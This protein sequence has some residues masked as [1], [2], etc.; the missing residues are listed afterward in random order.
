MTAPLARRS[1]TYLIIESWIIQTLRRWLQS[2]GFS[3]RDTGKGLL[4]KDGHE[5]QETISYR[6]KY[7]EE[8]QKL[9]KRSYVYS[10]LTEPQ[11]PVLPV[12]KQECVFVYHDECTF[13]SNDGQS[14]Y[15]AEVGE[16]HLKPKQQG[17]G[18]MVSGFLREKK[19]F[20]SA[21]VEEWEN[22]KIKQPHLCHHCHTP[23]H[24]ALATLSQFMAMYSLKIGKANATIHNPSGYWIADDVVGQTNAAVSIFEAS[25][26][27][28]QGVWI[29]DN[30]TGHGAYAH[31][32]LLVSRMNISPGGKRAH[33]EL[34]GRLNAA[35]YKMRSTSW[36]HKTTQQSFLQRMTFPADHQEY[37]GQ[38]KGIRQVRKQC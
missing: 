29:F 14:H 36:E 30:S 37:P 15:W 31:D 8:I 27:N 7:C 10:H 5:C 19:G 11:P 18:I 28:C 35:D 16:H 2:F 32:A 21:S 6:L 38:P 12:G 25:H 3:Y 13:H 34:G 4:Y 20:L 23:K 33:A 1:D 22:Y 24:K 26:P 9:S 17:T